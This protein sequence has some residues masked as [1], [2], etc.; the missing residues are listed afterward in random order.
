[1]KGGDLYD[2]IIKAKRL[3]EAQAASIIKQILSAI[4]Y[5]HM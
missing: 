2:Y 1:M 4:N 5:M 3:S